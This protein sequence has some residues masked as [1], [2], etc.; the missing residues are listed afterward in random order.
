MKIIRIKGR[1]HFCR[2]D[3]S[4]ISILGGNGDKKRNLKKCSR[5]KGAGVLILR[6]TERMKHTLNTL[7][8]MDPYQNLDKTPFGFSARKNLIFQELR[9]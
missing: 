1:K 9:S 7:N 6:L 4:H 3:I 5:T 8:D 2:L